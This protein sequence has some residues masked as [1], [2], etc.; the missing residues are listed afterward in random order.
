MEGEVGAP[1]RFPR[2]EDLLPRKSRPTR[3][4][5]RWPQCTRP[6]RLGCWTEHGPWDF[7]E[8]AS[9]LTLASLLKIIPLSGT[10]GAVEQV[11]EP[12]SLDQNA[13][14]PTFKAISIN[15]FLRLKEKIEVSK[16]CL[17][18][19]SS[20]SLN[21]FLSWKSSLALGGHRCKSTRSYLQIA[22]CSGGRCL[23]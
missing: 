23:E 10:W 2:M 5:K 4:P 16:I 20:C 12:D 15:S 19:R 7:P 1:V 9:T 13:Q 14:L 3:F 17:E 18:N 8:K 22:S 21:F 11:W 6:K